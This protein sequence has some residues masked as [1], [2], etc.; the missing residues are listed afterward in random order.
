MAK[1][2]RNSYEN[3]KAQFSNLIFLLPKNRSYVIIAFKML[4]TEF[5][6]EY[7]R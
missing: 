6:F 7:K 3:R 1:I 4:K 5:K 2:L